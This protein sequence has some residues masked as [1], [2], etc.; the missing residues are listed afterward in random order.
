ML[1]WL[2]L[3][4][5]VP[6][7]P[8]SPT[9]T[10][11]LTGEMTKGGQCLHGDFNHHGKNSPQSLNSPILFMFWQ[12]AFVIRHIFL[13]LAPD[14]CSHHSQLFPGLQED[15]G[16]HHWLLNDRR[17]RNKEG[18]DNFLD[19]EEFSADWRKDGDKE[20]KRVN[21]VEMGASWREKIQFSYFLGF[22]ATQIQMVWLSGLR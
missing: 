2:L 10:A 20:R 6:L 15:S 3:S 7:W 9:L 11:H 19:S 18:S 21:D 17:H 22:F 12:H 14:C 13:P 1:W 16:R 4:L 5:A 8:P